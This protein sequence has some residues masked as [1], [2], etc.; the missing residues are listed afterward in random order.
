M[1]TFAL[2][3]TVAVALF[4]TYT[5]GFHDSAN[6]IAT[7]VSTRALTPRAAL[8]MAAVMNLAGA[9]LGSGVAKTVSEGLIDTPEGSK[10]MGILFAAL[11]GAIVWNLV[12]WYYGLPSSSSHALFGG[13]VGAALAGG[14]KVYW[15]G[16]V[17]KIVIP[18]F[19]SPVVG[20]IVGYLVMTAIM[21]IFRRSNPHKAKRGFRIAQTVSA[22]GMALGHGLQDAQKT[23]GIV[24]MALVIAD[25]QEYGNTIPVWVKLV[26]AIML[27]LGTYAGGWRIMRTLGRKIIELDPPQGFAAETTGASIMFTTAF[28]F[29]APISTTHV[30][31]SAIMGVGATRR[32]NAVRWGVAKNIVL[33]WF[34][35]MPAAAIVAAVSFWVVDLAVL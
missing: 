4:F 9:F 13:M 10:G 6:A 32:V 8:A 3:V 7:S 31:T 33:G 35:T 29:K 18:M 14:I 27:S 25:V 17:D 30:I 19:L 28:L 12:T 16:V 5:N 26:C 24:M 22:A 11:V 21:W 20:L 23:M 15:S 34:I 2:V 1:D